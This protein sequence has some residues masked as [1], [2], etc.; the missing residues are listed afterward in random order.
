MLEH[1]I[2]AVP[3][4]VRAV[5]GL[6]HDGRRDLLQR[7]MQQVVRQDLQTEQRLHRHGLLQVGDHSGAV[8]HAAVFDRPSLRRHPDDHELCTYDDHGG[9]QRHARMPVGCDDD[10]IVQW[11]VRLVHDEG[12]S[13]DVRIAFRLRL[14]CD[15]DG[16]VHG[17][18]VFMR[19]PPVAGK[20]RG[21][22]R[23]HVAGGGG[24]VQWDGHPVHIAL[25]PDVL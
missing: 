6:R 25:Q 4:E 15:D 9:V 18:V 5:D 22:T 7:G 2:V 23:V 19:E 11:D 3:H 10:G 16:I 24:D 21:A 20:L 12:F 13:G 14:E 8:G 17:N 1:D